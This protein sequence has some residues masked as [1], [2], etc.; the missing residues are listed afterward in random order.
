M[1]LGYGR[2]IDHQ[3]IR[4]AEGG[5]D[6]LRVILKVHACPLLHEGIDK[7]GRGEVISCYLVALAEEV[8]YQGTHADPT[9][10]DEV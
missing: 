8:T 10:A 3:H 1:V 7:G 4:R 9:D 5:R 6:A 2:C